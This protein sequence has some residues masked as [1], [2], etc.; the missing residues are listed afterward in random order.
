MPSGRTQ[1]KH[2]PANKIALQTLRNFN[3]IFPTTPIFDSALENGQKLIKLKAYCHLRGKTSGEGPIICGVSVD[4]TNVRVDAAMV[5]DPQGFGSEADR[6]ISNRKVFPIW[7][8]AEN[9]TDYPGP[10]VGASPLLEDISL[11]GWTLEEGMSLEWF[12]YN[13]DGTSLTTGSDVTFGGV[14]ITRWLRD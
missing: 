10:S 2:L 11:P 3:S 9:I 8:F 5:G 4:L 1:I 7:V 6:L 14:I 12:A 13:A